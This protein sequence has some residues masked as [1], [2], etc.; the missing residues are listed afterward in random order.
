MTEDEA[1][2]AFDR[3]T[4]AVAAA[5]TALSAAHDSRR[6]ACAEWRAACV[7][8]DADLPRCVRR[9]RNGPGISVCIRRR[10]KASIWAS[11]PGE[12]RNPT[13]YTR[14]RGRQWGEYGSNSWD[15]AHLV[16][17]PEVGE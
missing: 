13:R 4:E 3:A 2:A 8:A 6:S 17:V 11:G 14:T 1:K 5:E 12:R 15:R 16:D 10:T 7:A 9:F